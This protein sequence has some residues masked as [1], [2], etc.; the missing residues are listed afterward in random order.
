MVSTIPE[1]P[2]NCHNVSADN[3]TRVGTRHRIL[4]HLLKGNNK[5]SYGGRLQDTS[6]F[7]QISILYTLFLTLFDHHSTTPNFSAR[8]TILV[9]YIY[10]LAYLFYNSLIDDKKPTIMRFIHSKMKRSHHNP[11]AY[12]YFKT[13]IKIGNIL[14]LSMYFLHFLTTNAPL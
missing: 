13:L 14:V 10:L 3:N 12:I 6:E 2:Q 9:T 11:S 7:H 5:A 1:E 4:K 8:L